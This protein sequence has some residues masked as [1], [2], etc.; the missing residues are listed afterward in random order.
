MHADQLAEQY[1]CPML[2]NH[3][4]NYLHNQITPKTIVE[5]ISTALRLERYDFVES[6]T[7][8]FVP[9]IVTIALVSQVLK[10][11]I[12][13]TN[14]YFL[15]RQQENFWELPLDYVLNLEFDFK[16]TIYHHCIL[17]STNDNACLNA[18]KK[19]EEMVIF[20]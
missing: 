3:C 14:V 12:V 20:C 8:Y 2:A 1:F 11:V 7:D 9:N 10:I 17:E 15:V 16:N 6:A 5:F 4:A 18:I 13:L 19:L